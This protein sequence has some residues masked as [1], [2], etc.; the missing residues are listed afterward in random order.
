MPRSPGR[1]LRTDA[2]LMVTVSRCTYLYISGNHSRVGQHE[3][4]DIDNV[5]SIFTS[6][7]CFS[8]RPA[9]NQGWQ[10]RGVAGVAGRQ[11]VATPGGSRGAAKTSGSLFFKIFIHT[12]L[13]THVG[14]LQSRHFHHRSMCIFAHGAIAQLSRAIAHILGKPVLGRTEESKY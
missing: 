10:G 9:R 7:S 2:R 14:R 6:S 3:E 13:R 8:V 12:E 1:T 4:H 5:Q 11:K